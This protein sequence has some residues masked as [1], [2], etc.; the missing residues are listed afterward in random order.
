MREHP[1]LLGSRLDGCLQCQ[2]L[3]L[4]SS[5]I[6]VTFLFSACTT[7]LGKVASLSIVAAQGWPQNSPPQQYGSHPGPFLDFL[8]TV[9][10]FESS[11]EPCF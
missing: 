5:G 10:F 9:T 1:L 6:S 3:L 4:A 11:K 7:Y 8:S 2:S